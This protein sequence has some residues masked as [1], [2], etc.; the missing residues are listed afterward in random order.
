MAKENFS[1]NKRFLLEILIA[2]FLKEQEKV[3]FLLVRLAKMY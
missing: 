1:V 2:S 3:L